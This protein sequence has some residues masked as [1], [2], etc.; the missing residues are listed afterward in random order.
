MRGLGRDRIIYTGMGKVRTLQACHEAHRHNPKV[1]TF[2]LIGFAGGL[3]GLSIGDQVEATEVLEYDF[4]ARPFEAYP[5]RLKNPNLKLLKDSSP[6]VFV[7]QDRFLTSFP[8]DL[9]KYVKAPRIACEMET[10]SL[11]LFA[12]RAKVKWHTV[13]LISD[14]ADPNAEHDFLKACTELTPELCRLVRSIQSQF[15]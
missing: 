4:D 10:Y 11:A 2:V 1:K 8:K 9:D 7:T 12:S 5:H 13:K 14:I 3:K 6:A 15:S